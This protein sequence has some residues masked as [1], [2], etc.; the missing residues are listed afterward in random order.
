MG[1]WH[2]QPETSGN[3]LAA[4]S[5]NGL[6]LISRQGSAIVAQPFLH[7]LAMGGSLG[8]MG[9]GRHFG[10]KIKLSNSLPH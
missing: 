2:L 3:I 4:I 5:R 8:G 9:H 10:Y 7:E 1:W 6:H